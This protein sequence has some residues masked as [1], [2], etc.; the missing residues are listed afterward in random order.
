[1][2]TQAKPQRLRCT[3]V[4]PV[5]LGATERHR[6]A[7]P[8][9]AGRGGPASR[10]RASRV[11]T[12]GIGPAGIRII[13]IGP[14]GIRTIGFGTPGIRTLGSRDQGERGAVRGAMGPRL[15]SLRFDSSRPH[16]NSLWYH[17]KQGKAMGASPQ[18]R[19]GRMRVRLSKSASRAARST[20]RSCRSM[21]A[22][23]PTASTEAG[24]GA[25]APAAPRNPR[26]AQRAS[27]DGNA[28]ASRLTPSST[29]PA[30]QDRLLPRAAPRE[31]PPSR[32]PALRRPC[33]RA[34]P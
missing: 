21:I 24:D 5:V 27:V 8:R 18:R 1:M 25:P 26:S 23:P 12:I 20:S 28:D 32:P 14:A 3:D 10:G 9:H 29:P 13:W 30:A 15:R 7:L 16:M 4:Y 6:H 2:F 33:P 11:R 31:G 19:L 17:A 22:Y 34:C